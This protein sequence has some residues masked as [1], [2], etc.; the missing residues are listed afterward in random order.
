MLHVSNPRSSD[1]AAVVGSG[2]GKKV[3]FVLAIFLSLHRRSRGRKQKWWQNST[4]LQRDYSPTPSNN[5]K[6]TSQDQI[7]KKDVFKALKVL[8]VCNPRSYGSAAVVGSGVGKDENAVLAIFLSLQRRSRC[9]KQK[10]WQN[11]TTLQRHHPNP[12]LPLLDL[13]LNPI[14]VYHY[15]STDGK[16]EFTC[17]P[18]KGRDIAIMVNAKM[19]YE[20]KHK[21]ILTLCRK[22][23]IHPLHFWE[24][25]KYLKSPY[26][27]N[28][29]ACDQRWSIK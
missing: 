23:T 7:P 8:H 25:Q 14:P 5:D 16:F 17:Y 24:W 1:S 6:T 18:S 22:F 26:Y 21:T 28:Y 11:S 20:V 3:K 12:G 9:R 13:Y 19:L 15:Q 4:T 27:K 29:G 10:W 2:V